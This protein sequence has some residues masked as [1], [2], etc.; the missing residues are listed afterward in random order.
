MGLGPE[1]TQRIGELRRAIGPYR[2]HL[3]HLASQ[4]RRS[5]CRTETPEVSWT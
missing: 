5:G 3:R 4:K 2:T 1:D